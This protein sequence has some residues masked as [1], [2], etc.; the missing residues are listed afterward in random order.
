MPQN[1]STFGDQIDGLFYIILAIAGFFFILTEGLL[2]YFMYTYAGGPGGTRAPGRPPLR[3]DQGALWTSFFKRIAG[4]VTAVI[5]NQHRLELFWTLVPARHPSVH[6]L[7]PGPTPGPRSSTRAHAR[8]QGPAPADRSQRPPVRVAHALPQPRPHGS[9]K[10]QPEARRELARVASAGDVHVVNEIHVCNG[11]RSWSTC[12]PGTCCTASTFPTSAEA[13]RRSGQESSR[14]VGSH[15]HRFQHAGGCYSTDEHPPRRTSLVALYEE[16]RSGLP[17]G[18][19]GGRFRP[20]QA[21]RTNRPRSGSWPAPS[22]A[23]GAI[24]RCRA[25]STSTKDEEDFRAWLA[26][27]E[28]EEQRHA[29]NNK[30]VGVLY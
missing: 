16:D 27:A 2:V 11:R 9:W 13:G 12:P 3:R 17:L 30:A 22:C 7:R 5:H 20:G 28:A 24:T 23:A 4:P 25:S 21:N 8:P 29:V 19:M 18:Q 1:V 26:A 6:R 14:S 15:G 10:E